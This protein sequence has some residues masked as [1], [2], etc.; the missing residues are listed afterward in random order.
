MVTL[1]CNLVV[2]LKAVVCH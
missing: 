2:F 1:N